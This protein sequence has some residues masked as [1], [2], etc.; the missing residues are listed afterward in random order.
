[1][2]CPKEYFCRVYSWFIL[3]RGIHSVLIH[4]LTKQE[5]L[6]HSDRAVWMGKPF[7]L[8]LTKIPENL[9]HVPLQYPELGLGYS[10]PQ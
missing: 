9:D 2:W 6:D 10:A 8:D 4:P 5:R 3:H 7:P 1:V